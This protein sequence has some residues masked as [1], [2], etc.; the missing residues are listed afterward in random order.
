MTVRYSAGNEE[1]PMDPVGRVELTIDADGRARLEH[2]S[3]RGHS[4]YEGAVDPADL[5]RLRQALARAGFPQVA[6]HR[7]VP[8]TRLCTLVVDDQSILVARGA[9]DYA[10]AFAILDSL[11]TELSE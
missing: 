8:D 3:R 9:P 6:N 11:V 7:I 5:D 2:F 1:N 10:E 4:E